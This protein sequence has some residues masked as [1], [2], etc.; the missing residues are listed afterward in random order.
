MIK[1]PEQESQGNTTEKPS[2]WTLWKVL[3]VEPRQGRWHQPTAGAPRPGPCPSQGSKK[4]AEEAA[5][6]ARTRPSS[7]TR[8][9]VRA[10]AP[11][12]G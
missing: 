9:L 6:T 4:Q 12:S 11:T 3:E 10:L 8:G 7:A 1:Q 5:L 2:Q